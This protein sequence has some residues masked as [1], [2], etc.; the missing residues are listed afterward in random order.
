MKI[1]LKSF[2]CIKTVKHTG[3]YCPVL[4]C[5]TGIVTYLTSF[6]KTCHMYRD[7]YSMMREL[8]KNIVVMLLFLEMKVEEMLLF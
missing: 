8:S 5:V 3:L 4:V 1:G 2:W 7:S 6:V